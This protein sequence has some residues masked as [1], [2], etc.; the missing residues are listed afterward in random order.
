MTRIPE[1]PSLIQLDYVSGLMLRVSQSLEQRAIAQGKLIPIIT[2][3][4][5]KDDDTYGQYH[6]VLSLIKDP[7]FNERWQSKRYLGHTQRCFAAGHPPFHIWGCEVL[8][9]F[10]E[11]AQ[12][13]W[14]ENVKNVLWNREGPDTIMSWTIPPVLIEKGV[15]L[16]RI[17]AWI[18]KS[19]SALENPWKTD[20]RMITLSGL[21]WLNRAFAFPDR[22]SPLT[23][24]IDRNMPPLYLHRNF[25]PAQ[26]IAQYLIE[27]GFV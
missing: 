22:F 18:G 16:P 11:N 8:R 10:Q 5:S 21:S 1:I 3:I 2:E 26:A 14:P 20:E 19:Q 9:S 12:Y 17:F 13:P 24:E 27:E 6:D 4:I 15:S 25:A 23:H 7:G